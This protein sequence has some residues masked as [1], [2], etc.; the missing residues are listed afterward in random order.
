M[1]D[2]ATLPRAAGY[3]I[4]LHVPTSITLLPIPEHCCRPDKTV[5]LLVLILHALNETII[6]ENKEKRERF[7]PNIFF[8]TL[9]NPT[10][11]LGNISE[12]RRS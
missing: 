12:R 3:I 7:A 4:Y 8:F 6:E 5:C 2:Q 10:L 1:T 11:V 9:T